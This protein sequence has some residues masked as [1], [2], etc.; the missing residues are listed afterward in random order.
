MTNHAWG[1]RHNVARARAAGLLVVASLCAVASCKRKADPEAVPVSTAQA[2]AP[3]ESAPPVPPSASA[4]P[5]RVVTDDMV[6]VPAGSFT[7]GEDGSKVADPAHRVRISKPFYIDRYEVRVDDYATCVAASSCTPAEVHGPKVAP[8]EAEKFG[9]MCNARYPDREDHPVN[10]VDQAQAAA[11]CKFA[12]KRLPTE[13]EWE[14]AARGSDER[15]Y[16][17]GNDSPG[18]NKAVVSGCAARVVG[19]ASTQSVGSFPR[20]KSPFGAH[21]MAGNVWE[22]V[23]DTW[24]EDAYS[25]DRGAD[26]KVEGPGAFGVLRGGSWDFAPSH[27]ASHYRLKF[28]RAIGHVSTG[29]RCAQDA[30]ARSTG[31]GGPATAKTASTGIAANVGAF[32]TAWNLKAPPARAPL[33][34]KDIEVKD[35]LFLVDLSGNNKIGLLGSVDSQGVVRRVSVLTSDSDGL[36]ERMGAL[37]AMKALMNVVDA[38]MTNALQ[39]KLL[40]QVGFTDTVLRPGRASANGFTYIFEIEKGSSANFMLE[41]R[42]SADTGK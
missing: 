38:E 36:A 24:E 1:T 14:Y 5:R 39:S 29:M 15:Q 27:L 21:D 25:R 30:A 6:L 3:S 34:N 13:A 32:R 18:C 2:P 31:A 16:P 35:G 7:M 33:I 26:P 4:E 17:W 10:C 11:F 41:A 28:S 23:A 40:T 8:P 19:K 12:G 9:P 22:W 20:G 42:L 37:H